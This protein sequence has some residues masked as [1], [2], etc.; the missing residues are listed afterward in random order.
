MKRFA[1]LVVFAS[2]LGCGTRPPLPPECE[3]ALRPINVPAATTE[4]VD[5][6]RPHG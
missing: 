5:E 3:G 2:V 4:P 6:S 1:A